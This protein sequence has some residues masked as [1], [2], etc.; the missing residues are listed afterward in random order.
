MGLIGNQDSS[1]EE[2]GNLEF[3]WW[4]LGGGSQVVCIRMS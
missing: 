4:V 2:L 1:L 3:H